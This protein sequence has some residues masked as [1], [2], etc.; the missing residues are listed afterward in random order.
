M[1]GPGRKPLLHFVVLGSL[2]FGAKQLTSD[3]RALGIGAEPVVIAADEVERLRMEWLADTRRSPSRRELEA[4]IRTAADDEILLREALRLGL[5]RTDTV[6]RGR[7]LQNMRF[8]LGPDGADSALLAEA[9]ALDMPRRDVVTRRRLVQAMEERLA[10]PVQVGEAEV[11]AFIAA[12]PD[13]YA[14]RRRVTLDQVFIPRDPASAALLPAGRLE[15][16]SEA[17][18]A[19]TFGE[20]FARAAMAAPPGTWAGPIRSAYGSHVIRVDA[21][22]EPGIDDPAVLRQAWFALLQQRELEASR[23][24]IAALRRAYPVRVDWPKLALAERS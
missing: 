22:D 14:P 10:G 2:L 16:Q 19:R 3:G 15:R 21:A 7:L 11:R 18:L 24:G 12:H 4:A 23:A 20:E 1:K 17:D 9:Y 8:S 5:D 13:R 6:V